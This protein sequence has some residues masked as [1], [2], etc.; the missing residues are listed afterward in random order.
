MG[1]LIRKFVLGEMVTLEVAGV[2]SGQEEP[3][4]PVVVQLVPVIS[5]HIEL[6]QLG[7]PHVNT[8]SDP[9]LPGFLRTSGGGGCLWRCS[10]MQ[11]LNAH[12][13]LAYSMC[14]TH[15]A[16]HACMWLYH[17]HA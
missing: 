4:T 14:I 7:L 8:M 17:M 3:D 15:S 5:L 2:S 16:M 6:R 13:A 1:C 11:M 9:A 12:V 10:Y